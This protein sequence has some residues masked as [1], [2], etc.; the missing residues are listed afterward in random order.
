M[1]TRTGGARVNCRHVDGD[2]LLPSHLKDCTDRSCQGCEPCLTDDAGNPTRHCRSRPECAGHLKPDQPQTCPRCIGRVRQALGQIEDMSAL[3][4]FAAIEANDEDSEPTMLAGPAADP[5]ARRHRYAS[6]RAGR[7]PLLDAAGDRL[8]E[9]DTEH[10]INV[11]GWW[12]LAFRERYGQPAGMV[13]NL[14][15][16]VAYLKSMLDAVAQE[17]GHEWRAFTSEV[18]DCRSHL[19]HVL[20]TAR[21]TERGTVCPACRE[22]GVEHPPR[23][24]KHYV[25]S[26]RSG[27]SDFWACPDQPK[28][29]RWK[30]AA[31]RMRVADDYVEH[32]A[33]LTIT[34]LAV[35]LEVPEGTLRRWAG[36]KFIGFVNDEPAYT[37]PK[38][39][40][41]G[42]SHDGR[43]LYRVEDAA[44]LAER[45][46]LRGA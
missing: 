12:V 43:R 14:S 17:P 9:D 4:L 46:V 41:C 7:I 35:R 29:H 2:Y 23:L 27:A 32:A 24:E 30:E 15:S 13:L 40:P 33:A 8:G 3:M 5:E 22:D 37:E 34:D 39:K 16:S 21:F 11:L 6:A 31:Y 28:E 10:P 19:E 25:R 45:R 18:L 38:L 26:D 44:R 42:R 20:A 1:T 36:R